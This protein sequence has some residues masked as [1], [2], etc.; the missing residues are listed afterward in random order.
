MIFCYIGI[1]FLILFAISF[2]REKRRFR[3]AVYLL[4]AILNMGFYIVILMIGTKNTILNLVVVVLALCV[5]PIC[6]IVTSILFIAAGIITIKREGFRITNLL[7]L[8]FGIGIWTP[9]I[10]FCL[11]EISH[12][13]SKWFMGIT[14]FSMLVVLYIGFT[15]IA[16]LIYSSIYCILPKGKNY[17]YIIIHGAGLLSGERVSPLLAKRIDKGIEAF[18]KFDGKAKI[19]V[20][21]GKG[22]DEKISE[23]EA[24][25]RYLLQKNIGEENVICEDKST[26][27]FENLQ[28][29]KKIMDDE[30][31][32]Y[33]CIFV[34]NN[35]HVFRTGLFAKKIKL[36]AE[37]LGCKTAMYYLPSAFIREYIAI[38]WY[39]KWYSI[40]ILGIPLLAIILNM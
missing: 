38:M 36:K 27:T 8:V 40:F 11:L 39:M 29:S 7:A 16:L 18:K 23:A 13:M 6:I 10:L 20:S 2:I 22:S 31:E 12:L 9:L 24:M 3:N 33:K 21:G 26:T 37:G 15:F 14:Y 30:K 34:T 32:N 35:Y 28:Y 5:M 17:D 25:K 4:C 1:I 19:I